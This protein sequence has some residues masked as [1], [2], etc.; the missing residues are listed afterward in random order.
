M[1]P[2]LIDQVV[3]DPAAIASSAEWVA[4]LGP[5]G[6]QFDPTVPTYA[7][8]VR[9]IALRER[10]WLQLLRGPDVRIDI[11][12]IPGN[13]AWHEISDGAITARF[14]GVGGGRRLPLDDRGLLAYYGQPQHFLSFAMIASSD[15]PG[16]ADLRDLLRQDIHAERLATARAAFADAST[17]DPAS[18]SAALTAAKSATEIAYQAVRSTG[19][20][21][22]GVYRGDRLEYPDLFGLGR[23]PADHDSYDQGGFSLWYEVVETAPQEPVGLQNRMVIVADVAGYSPRPEPLQEE[24]QH[25]L[26]R[27][28]AQVVADLKV[29]EAGVQRQPTGDGVNVV[30]PADIDHSTVLPV[31]LRTMKTRLAYDNAGHDDQM[32]VRLAVHIG[33]VR[34]A[35]LGFTGG[36]LVTASRLVDSL[37]LRTVLQTRPELELAAIVSDVVHHDVAIHGFAG[38]DPAGFEGADVTVKTFQGKG[39]IWVAE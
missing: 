9:E 1:N 6:D 15:R 2:W 20:A 16:T 26:H 10:T 8:R 36:G 30:L 7:V 17:G 14:P 29:R 19:G 5:R 25:R 4:G 22:I 34:V 12:A 39:W 18:L 37:A 35:P 38:L 13:L 32:R 24:I 33:M 21:V 23:N 28:M 31:L 27:L 11:L 3:T